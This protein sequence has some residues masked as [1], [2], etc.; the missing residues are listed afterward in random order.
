MTPNPTRPKNTMNHTGPNKAVGILSDTH[1]LVRPE[2]EAALAGCDHI[3]HAGDVGD[4]EVLE[5]LGQI[6]PVTAVRGNMDYG[7]WS[8][9]LPVFDMPDIGG[10]FFYPPA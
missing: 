2:V 3:L 5:K 8:N 4:P 10:V 1:G 7:S 6:A 9:A